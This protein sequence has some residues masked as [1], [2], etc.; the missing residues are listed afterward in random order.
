MDTG[1]TLTE[2]VTKQLLEE[3]RGGIYENQ[4]RLPPE[5][6]IAVSIGVSRTVVRDAL[7]VLEREGFIGRKHG[8][9]TL[10]N[11]H[12]LQMQ[13]RMDLEQEF[14]EEVR[15]CGFTPS[16]RL[17]K[18]EEMRAD[19]L[20]AHHLKIPV[21]TPVHGVSCLI[22]AD[23]RPAIYCIDY[24]PSEL[25]VRGG[26]SEADFSHCIFDFLAKYCDIDVHMDITGVR[27]IGA[28]AQVAKHL[29]LAFATPVLYM[30]E[31]GYTFFG[32]PVLFSKEY[33]VDGIFNHTIL[34]KKI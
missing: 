33:Y 23:G 12:V 5:K 30:A 20:V 34:R 21:D 17:L 31:L 8:V 29:E 24:F 11:H 3:I 13:N 28:D 16:R 26:Y 27:A 1:Q 32:K 25:I 19:E 22:C 10:I 7:S 9:G 2:M 18:V 15:V 4:Q 6:D 14:C